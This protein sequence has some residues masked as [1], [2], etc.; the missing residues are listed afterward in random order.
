MAFRCIASGN[1][2]TGLGRSRRN[3]ISLRCHCGQGQGQ[4]IRIRQEGVQLAPAAAELVRL[5]RGRVKGCADIDDF[6]ETTN[7]KET[8]S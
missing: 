8:P 5:V 2:L 7:R 6:M 4:D 1:I 3:R